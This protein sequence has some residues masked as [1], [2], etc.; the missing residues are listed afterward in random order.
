[1]DGQTTVA[2]GW[3]RAVKIHKRYLSV[4]LVAVIAALLGGCAS[5]NNGEQP[6][7]NPSGTGAIG[8]IDSTA[9][10]S[11]SAVCNPCSTPPPLILTT[12]QAA[13]EHLYNAWKANDMASAG[14]GASSSAVTALFAKAWQADTYFFG[15][16]TEPSAPSECDY[17]WAGGIVAMTI[18]GDPAVGFQVSAVSFGNAG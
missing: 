6:G 13:A 1:M 16:C 17:N 14:L 12:P 8:E 11:P 18:T 10:A 7:S 4:A 15:G 3:D 2:R 9:S 5:G